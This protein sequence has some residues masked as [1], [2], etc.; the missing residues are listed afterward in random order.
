MQFIPALFAGLTGSG[1]AAGAG[2]AAGAT[3][4]G[5]SAASI[6]SG[7]A[8]IGGAL[9]TLGAAK[10]QSNSYKAAAQETETEAV[11]ADTQAVQKQTQMKRELMRVLGENSVTAAAAGLDL[12]SGIAADTNADAEAKAATEITIDR[13]SQDARRAAFR[14]RA[15]GLRSQAKSAMSAGL[16]NA[17]GQVAGGGAEL[18]KRG[19]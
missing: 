9:A 10:S 18:L 6:L 4:T 11:A 2:V 12:G 19:G 17:F 16:F 7:V 5:F 1:A 3:A 14:A 15:A 8:T 13:S